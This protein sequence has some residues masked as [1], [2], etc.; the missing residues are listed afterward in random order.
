[1]IKAILFDLDGTLVR[2]EDLK[3]LG[4]ARA[5]ASIGGG[6]ISEDQVLAAY[7]DFVGLPRQEVSDGLLNR[8]FLHDAVRPAM[9]KYGVKNPWEAFSHL[10]LRVY[11]DFLKDPEVVEEHTC[12]YNVGLLRW[13]REN[14]Y[15]TGLATMSRL[16]QVLRIL[17]L[18]EIRG[19]F[20]V[21]ATRD[22]VVHP[23]PDP[24]IYRTVARDL[25]LAAEECLVVEDSPPGITA[26]L[27][28]GM[29][30]VAVTTTMT[31]ASVHGSGLL[32]KEWIVDDPADLLGVVRSGLARLPQRWRRG[33]SW[34]TGECYSD[35]W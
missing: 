12:P 30:C 1:M 25:S 14:G 5:A 16:E 26:A 27:R 17:D 3:G 4:Y 8:F 13:A 28:A 24:E 22:D 19:E 21:I 29:L 23:K 11:E 2:T 20:D 9:Q 32:R 31:R 18:L 15:R 35:R 10:R 33:G 34:S 6:R 7:R